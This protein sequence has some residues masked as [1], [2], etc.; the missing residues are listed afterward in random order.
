[1]S[2]EGYADHVVQYAPDYSLCTGCETCAILCGLTHFEV[3][4]PHV[5]G[6]YAR[7]NGYPHRR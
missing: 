3:T 2:G 4:G 7:R 1:M 5:S 6:S